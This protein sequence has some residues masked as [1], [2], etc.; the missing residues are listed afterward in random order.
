MFQLS[1]KMSTRGQ[2]LLNMIQLDTVTVELLTLSPVSYEAYISSFGHSNRQQVKKINGMLLCR[3][4][5]IRKVI[6]VTAEYSFEIT[7]NNG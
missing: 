4:G 5:S 3:I 7:L 1:S 6:Y 2:K